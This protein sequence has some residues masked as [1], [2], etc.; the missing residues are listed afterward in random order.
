MV[1]QLRFLTKCLAPD[2]KVETGDLPSVTTA[3]VDGPERAVSGEVGSRG[4]DGTEPEVED[5]VE[6]EDDEGA[7]SGSVIFSSSGDDCIDVVLDS[8]NTDFIACT[9]STA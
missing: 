9:T 4:D 2:G 6:D 8:L 3:E 7:R 1:V 5:D